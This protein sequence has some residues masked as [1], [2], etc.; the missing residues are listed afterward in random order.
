MAHK[1]ATRNGIENSNEFATGRRIEIFPFVHGITLH[2]FESL[3]NIKRNPCMD[4]AREAIE[5]R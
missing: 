5:I 4:I 1:D 3:V 2:T